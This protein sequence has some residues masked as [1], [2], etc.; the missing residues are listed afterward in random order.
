MLVNL[1]FTSLSYAKIDS[2]TVAGLGSLMKALAIQ[3]RIYLGNGNDGTLMSKPKWV[4]GKYGRLCSL[5]VPIML[6]AATVKAW[7]EQMK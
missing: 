3:L 2:K 7:Y 6:A 5:V 1:L 4:K